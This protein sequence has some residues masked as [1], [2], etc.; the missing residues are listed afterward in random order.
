MKTVPNKESVGGKYMK[1][2]KCA[3][4]GNIVAFVKEVQPKIICC[5][6]PMTE[7]VPNT[8]DAAKEKHVPVYTVK[9]GK[10][11]VQV[12]AVAHP[13]AE[14]HYIEWIVLE[15]EQGRQRKQ[16]QPGD[17]PEA[18][19]ALTAGDKVVAVYAYCNKHG[20]WKA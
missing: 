18:Q 13:M 11:S 10:V 1:F 17:K 9:C 14:D 16:L 8:V 15:S 5:G 19:F 3:H 2:M 20:L 12:G 4:C 7:L 6:E